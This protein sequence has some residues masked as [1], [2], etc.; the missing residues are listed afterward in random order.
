MAL[1]GRHRV[2]TA[3]ALAIFSLMLLCSLG[4]VGAEPVVVMNDLEAGDKVDLNTHEFRFKITGETD[5]PETFMIRLSVNQDPYTGWV[6]DAAGT[7]TFSVVPGGI[8]Q[9]ITTT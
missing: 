7:I 4:S 9:R 2:L 6:R 3:I 5:K 1:T 8:E